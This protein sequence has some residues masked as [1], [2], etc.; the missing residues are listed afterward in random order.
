VEDGQPRIV[1][2]VADERIFV[3]IDGETG[4]LFYEIEADNL[5]VLHTEVPASLEGRGVGGRLVR[6]ALERARRDH[7][8]VVPWCPFA[9]QW[10]R[11]H[12]DTAEGVAIDWKRAPAEGA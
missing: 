11:T 1:D 4:D 9:R 3:E 7:L 2:D 10:I 5:L 6:A 12:P 8:T